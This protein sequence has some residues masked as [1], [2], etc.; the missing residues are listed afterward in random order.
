MSLT[1]TL[2]R[3]DRITNMLDRMSP[4]VL[5]SAA[6]LVFA[7][8]LL[9]YFLGSAMTKFDTPF[10]LSSGAFFQIFPQQTDAVY[11]DESQLNIFYWL[12]VYLGSY[13]EIF[14]P[15]FITVGFMARLSSLGMI[16]FIIVQ[17]LTDIYGH[18]VDAATVGAWFDR[19]SGA[20]IADQR[21]YWILG[22]M[23]IVFQGA[24]PLS[25]DRLIK[26]FTHKRTELTFM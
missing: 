17:S 18:G 9:M 25:V 2:H 6:R 23:I 21:A 22:L 24:G 15:L 1:A 19:S 11:G 7:G 5:P 10:T 20:L 16:G 12:I 8:V 14:L 13:A 3:L 4:V 26:K